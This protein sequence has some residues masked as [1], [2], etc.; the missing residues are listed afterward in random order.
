VTRS[1]KYWIGKL[2][3]TSKLAASPMT[4]ATSIMALLRII[5]TVLLMSLGVLTWIE[6]PKLKIPVSWRR[7][8]SW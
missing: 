6:I 2:L 1:A 5:R 4:R 8:K 3:D 7:E